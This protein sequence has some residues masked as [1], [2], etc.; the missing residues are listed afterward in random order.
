MKIPTLNRRR[1]AVTAALVGVSMLSMAACA[2]GKSIIDAGNDPVPLPTIPAPPGATTGGFARPAALKP[3]T[4][5]TTPD[6]ATGDTTAGTT[7]ASD[8]STTQASSATTATSEVPAP[9]T[10]APD[11]S[12]CPVEALDAASGP[13]QITFWNPLDQQVHV[14]TMKSLVDQY[15]ASQDKVVVTVQDQQ[16][17]DDN[18]DKF[19]QS[20]VNGRP[21]MTLH[22]EFAFQQLID[23]GSIIPIGSCI[24]ASGFDTSPIIP[25]VLAAHQVAGTQWGIAFNVSNPVLYYNKAM[26][27]AAGLDPEKPPVTFDEVR[28]YS[29]QIVDSGAASFGL[30]LESGKDS[31]GGWFLEQWLGQAGELFADNENGRS[32]R[33]TQVVFDTPVATEFLTQVQS[34]ITDGLAVYVGENAG[35]IDQFLRMGD[36]SSPTAMAIG[37]SAG[38]GPVM[39]ALGGGLVPGLTTD[40]VGVGPLPGPGVG[41]A[42]GGAALY[43]TAD[44][45]PEEIA[46]SWDF[47]QFLLSAESQSTWAAATGYVPIRQ[48][49]VELD[50][51]KTTYANDPRFRVPFDQ[52]TAVQLEPTNQFPAIGPLPE[53][54]GIVAQATGAIMQGADVQ[55]SLDAAK[56]Q[57]DALIAQYNQLNG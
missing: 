1:R 55:A 18:L 23:S 29:Q 8:D 14:D 36:Q 2:S 28:Q 51:L 48:D 19:N 54:R 16:G 43:I 11:P 20:D 33:A 49:A 45:S 26:F 39:A 4:A 56:A 7:A 25:R 12:R 40:Q 13:V 46:A 41:A 53:I 15:N 34:L 10:V 32:D 24:A 57:A 21:A 47:A 44:K 22:P 9:T 6:T 38:I 50:P 3:A 17:Y 37:T 31:G 30:G 27:E 42:V 5:T 52:L 35:G